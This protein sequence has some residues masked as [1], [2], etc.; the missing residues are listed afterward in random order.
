MKMP[1]ILD[2]TIIDQALTAHI[3]QNK[4]PAKNMDLRMREAQRITENVGELVIATVVKNA[5]ILNL[6]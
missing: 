3:L 4:W 5:K 1:I 6:L 2:S